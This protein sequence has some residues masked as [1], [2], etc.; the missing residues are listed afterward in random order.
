MK[1]VVLCDTHAG[2]RNSSDIFL[3]YFA[4]FYASVL[5]PY[6]DTHGIRHIVHLGD[7]YD[8]RKRV[9]FKALNHNR[10][11]F[12]E[13]MTERSMTMDIIPGNHDVVYKSTNELCSLKE[14]LGYFMNNVHIVMEPRVMDYDGCAIA[15]LPWINSTNYEESINFIKNCK[16][17]ILGAHLELA[18][19]DIMKGMPSHE[20]M[21]SDIFSRF[22]QVW[23]G[24]YH[25]RSTKGNVHY[26]GAPYEMTWVDWN[27]PKY[28]H[29]FDTETR[30]LTPVR[31]PLSIFHK[32]YYDDKTRD[33]QKYDHSQC[34][35]KFVKVIVVNKKDRFAFD[36]FVDKIQ[37]R[38]I[39]ELKITENYDELAADAIDDDK[40]EIST[41]AD[42]LSTYVDAIDT[43][44]DRDRIKNELHMLYSEAQT[45]ELV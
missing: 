21:S 27:D 32:I 10:K 3:N 29:V 16:A 6:C 2:A 12:L 30:V 11:H 37:T 25:T 17:S 15:L 22:E 39:H 34:D 26:L 38:S 20:G 7:F 35:G 19:F 43:S 40:I 18:G 24:H 42:L 36:K 41:T 28:F 8:D 4:A 1:F 23:T 33:Y 14:L 45:L 31:N 5:F 44:L 13:P 9:N